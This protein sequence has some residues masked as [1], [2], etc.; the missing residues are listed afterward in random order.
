MCVVPAEI[1]K[2]GNAAVDGY[3]V[4]LRKGKK[5]MPRC[6][7][8][9]LGEAGVGKTNLLN[10]LTGE[11]FVPT[12]ERTEGVD[13]SLVETF[14]IDTK[15]WKKNSGQGGD[16]EYRRIAATEVASRLKDTKPVD[17]INVLPTP[18]ALHQKFNS[19]MRKYAEPTP[20]PKPSLKSTTST[21]HMSS[22]RSTK[23]ITHTDHV[24]TPKMQFEP[25]PSVHVRAHTRVTENNSVNVRQS[26]SH[27][28]SQDDVAV[29]VAAAA[30]SLVPSSSS[31]TLSSSTQ[32]MNHVA[33][34]QPSGATDISVSSSHDHLNIV[35]I[36]REA[37]KQ[38]FSEPL[39]FHLKLTS[40][41]FAGQEHYKSMH[42]CF[43]TSRAVYIVTFNARDLLTKYQCVSDINYWVNSILVH[44]SADAKVI[45]V[46]THRGP[47]QHGTCSFDR[48]N[49]RDEC[50]IDELLKRHLKNHFVFSFFKGDRI[51]AVV[52]SSIENNE[53]ISGAKVV[54]EKLKILGEG[55][56]G[57]KDDL[58]LSYLRLESKIFE[59]RS[60]RFEN[61]SFLIP[62][63][64]V[65]QWANDFGIEDIKT[66]LDFLHDIGIIVNPSK[67]NSTTCPFSLCSLNANHL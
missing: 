5:K 63:D 10:L 55:H 13:I 41:D 38:K 25:K 51:M 9:I 36:L 6:K 48:L 20:N 7:L 44:T 39:I 3:I 47:Y 52:E 49:E 58:P 33:D 30:V 14:D 64:E 24:Q 56:P 31:S 54:R 8:V 43:M 62:H 53:D 67:Q 61:K 45:L 11:K 42:P 23:H 26:T 28:R 29:A 22:S 32:D 27:S 2:R 59:E 17:K 66:A 57:N 46:G 16:D 35:I 19:I 12:H 40:F 37:S 34:T 1:K 60:K 21:R 15:T 50:N 65:E 18:K 4:A